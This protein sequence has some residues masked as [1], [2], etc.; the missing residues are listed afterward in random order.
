M[1]KYC[2]SGDFDSISTFQRNAER[3]AREVSGSRVIAS[4]RS[5]GLE[6][7]IAAP[8]SGRKLDGSEGRTR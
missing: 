2:A 3:C 8:E 4:L 5:E 1:S 6:D 7:I